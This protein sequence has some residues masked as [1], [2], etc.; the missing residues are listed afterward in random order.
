M[1]NAIMCAGCAAV[2]PLPTTKQAAAGW[3]RH[4][5]Q[6]N[7]RIHFSY[8]CPACPEDKGLAV[9]EGMKT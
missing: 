9:L 8:T 6:W 1:S 3:R 2:L 5:L 7:L 4:S